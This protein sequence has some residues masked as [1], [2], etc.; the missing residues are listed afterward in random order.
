MSLANIIRTPLGFGT[1]PLGNLFRK[2]SEEDAQDTLQAAWDTG[3]RY[4]D[5]AP[6]YGAGL[7]EIRLGEALSGRPRDSFVLSTKV[8]RVVLDE[9]EPAAHR[10]TGPYEHGRPNK[11][12]DDWSADATKRSLEDSLRRLRVDRID[13]VWVHDIAQDAYGDLWLQKLEEARTGAFRVLDGLRDEGVIGAWGIGVNRTEPI[14]IAL[15]LEEPRPDGFLLGGC[16]TLLDHAHA[17]QRLLPMAQEQG[18]QMV[19]GAPYN[20]GI[21]AGGT[22]FQYREAPPRVLERVQLIGEA[23]AEYGVTTKALALQFVLAHPLAVAVIPGASRPD[24]VAEDAA[25]L[26]ERVPA[27]LWDRLRESGLISP[28]APLPGDG[29]RPG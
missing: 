26:H 12:V 29:G 22:H 7:S 1:G 27:A 9:E 11:I 17:L 21:L 6:L 8:G 23:A 16:Y 2:I 5:S 4:Y 14:E 10:R 3:I 18:V 25:A 20:S 24:R 28:S 19:V 13:I 15:T